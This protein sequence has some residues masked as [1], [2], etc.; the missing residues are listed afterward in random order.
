MTYQM[1]LLIEQRLADLRRAGAA[2]QNL[3]RNPHT[4][5]RAVRVRLGG[6]LVRIGDR[7]GQPAGAPALR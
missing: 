7:L 4:W 2:S 1:E 3:P 5:R 6:T